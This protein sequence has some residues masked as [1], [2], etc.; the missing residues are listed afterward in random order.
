MKKLEEQF[1][2]L[3]WDYNLV[4]RNDIYA[5]FRKDKKAIGGCGSIVSYETIK[6]QK[7]K[8]A[9]FTRAGEKCF[10]PAQEGYP[11]DERWG[12]EGWSFSSAEKAIAKLNELT[13]NHINK[14][15]D[16]N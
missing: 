10:I 14:Q 4:H 5:V 11:S 2:R 8:D 6:I 3:G 12:S 1:K 15:N 7:R 13:Q 16:E 9:E